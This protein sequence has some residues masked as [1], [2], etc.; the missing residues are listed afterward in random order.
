MRTHERFPDGLD[1]HW[2]AEAS[3]LLHHGQRPCRSAHHP[4]GQAITGYLITKNQ[5]C[6]VGLGFYAFSPRSRG[7]LSWRISVLL[8]FSPGS[9]AFALGWS[10]LP[11]AFKLSG[12]ISGNHP[13]VPNLL[14]SATNGISGIVQNTFVRTSWSPKETSL[15][16]TFWSVA[17]PVRITPSPKRAH[18]G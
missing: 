17:F 3:A 16:T 11:P 15:H 4:D 6:T 8:S 12:R 18:E 5:G 9:A 13:C 14:S 7:A 2:D 1:R 10:R